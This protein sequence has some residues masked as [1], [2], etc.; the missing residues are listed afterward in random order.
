MFLLDNIASVLK[1]VIVTLFLYIKNDN[2]EKSK[3]ELATLIESGWADGGKG[4]GMRERRR[5]LMK[6]WLQKPKED[7][8]GSGSREEDVLFCTYVFEGNKFYEFRRSR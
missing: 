5:E 8:G 1:T 4:E 2:N 6:I 7:V 3:S